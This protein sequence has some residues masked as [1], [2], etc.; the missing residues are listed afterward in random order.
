[1]AGILRPTQLRLRDL[2]SQTSVLPYEHWIEAR[3]SHKHSLTTLMCHCRPASSIAL[4]SPA[5]SRPCV[6]K[7]LLTTHQ[8]LAPGYDILQIYLHLHG[9]LCLKCH[10]PAHLPIIAL[11]ISAQSQAW[12]QHHHQDHLHQK[13]PP[14]GRP[15]GTH[16]TPNG[17]T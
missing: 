16:N 11:I 7:P 10:T 4:S 9:R 15:S 14:A 6:H 5:D 3:L 17:S 8:S 2:L 12:T 13:S 1:M